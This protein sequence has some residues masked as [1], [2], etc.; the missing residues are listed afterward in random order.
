MGDDGEKA[1]KLRRRRE[2]R[3]DAR[4]NRF[5]RLVSES[6]QDNP[7][8]RQTSPERQLAKV[9]IEGQ[10]Y[11]TLPMSFGD[12]VRIG[13]ARHEVSHV[14]D[15]MTIGSEHVGYGEREVLVGNEAFAH[16]ESASGG[17]L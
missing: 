13:R 10:Q 3:S 12:D 5:W 9:E 6:K 7:Y 14:K 4:D 1:P 17:R 2:E 15:I 8:R 11:G 16:R